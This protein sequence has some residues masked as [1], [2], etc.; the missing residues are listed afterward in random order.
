MP[1]TRF[2]SDVSI[3]KDRLLPRQVT[4]VSSLGSDKSG[5]QAPTLSGS[6]I[7]AHRFRR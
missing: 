2:V 4:S 7:K 3:L 6:Y 5:Q 1:N